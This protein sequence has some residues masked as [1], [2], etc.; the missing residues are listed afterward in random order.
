MPWDWRV[1]KNVMERIQKKSKEYANKTMQK[2]C[3]ERLEIF[4]AAIF[5]P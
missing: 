5:F 2:F 4:L 3:M 1:K